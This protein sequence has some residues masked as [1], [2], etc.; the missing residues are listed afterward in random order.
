MQLD[1]RRV[2]LNPGGVGQPRD[3][4]PRACAMLLD[5]GTMVAEWFRVSY[6][7]EEVQEL[8]RDAGLPERLVRRLEFG[9]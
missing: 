1:D 2:I 7:V 3:G 6:P 8:M 9:L 5:T 4:D